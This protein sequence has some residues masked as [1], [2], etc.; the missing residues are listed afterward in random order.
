MCEDVSENGTMYDGEKGRD[1]KKSSVEM[2]KA[3]GEMS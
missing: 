1:E 3:R 2:K